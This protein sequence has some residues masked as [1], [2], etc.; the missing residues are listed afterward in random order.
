MV[1]A[2]SCWSSPTDSLKAHSLWMAQL[3]P[4]WRAESRVFPSPLMAPPSQRVMEGLCSWGHFIYLFLLIYFL[5]TPLHVEVPRPGMEPVRQLQPG[6]QLRQCRILN[7]LHHKG[8]SRAL[9]MAVCQRSLWGDKILGVCFER[10]LTLSSPPLSLGDDSLLSAQA[11]CWG[12]RGSPD[13]QV[14]GLFS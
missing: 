4:G 8:T 10:G 1:A 9:Q 5:A 2:W 3:L 13:V 7:P 6:P 11:L 14:R 12:Q